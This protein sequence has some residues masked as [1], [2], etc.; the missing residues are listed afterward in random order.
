MQHHPASCVTVPF[1]ADSASQVRRA[2]HEDLAGHGVADLATLEATHVIYELV[3]NGVEHGRPDPQD[4]L[5]V[6]WIAESAMLRIS[7]L[8][9]GGP[10][11]GQRIVAR[12]PSM[13]EPGGRGLAMVAAFSD[14]WVSDRTDGTRVTA[15]VRLHP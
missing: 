1:A 12:L 5:E 7:V 6:S 2:L 13:D 11:D 3:M 10:E 15:W 14:R 4:A 9:R 8:D